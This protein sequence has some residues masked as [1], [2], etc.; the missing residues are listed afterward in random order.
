MLERVQRRATKM[1]TCLRNIEYEQRLEA[2]GLTTLEKRRQRGDLIETYKILSGCYNVEGL[3][4]I[5]VL[6]QN[7]NLRGHSLKLNRCSSKSNPRYHFLPNR[8]ASEWNKLP[9]TV[10]SAPSVNSFKNRLDKYMN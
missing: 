3:K 5:Y 7:K 1:V 9:E 8:V 2:L 4:D 10:I 6:S